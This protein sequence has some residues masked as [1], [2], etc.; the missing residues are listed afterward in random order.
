LASEGKKKRGFPVFISIMKWFSAL[1]L[2]L[3]A[4]L[5]SSGAY[6]IGLEM[7]VCVAALVVFGQ[8]LRMRKYVWGIGFLAMSILFNPAMPI[9]MPHRISLG[10]EWISIVAFLV[11]LSG[12]RTR[13]LLSIPSITGRTPGSESL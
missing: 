5:S 6:R 1:A 8:A 2:L 3:G 4:V 11:S 7:L 12:L 13:P 10:L 9:P